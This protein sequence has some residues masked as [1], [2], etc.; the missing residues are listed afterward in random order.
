[1][2][3]NGDEKHGTCFPVAKQQHEAEGRAAEFRRAICL[4][5]ARVATGLELRHNSGLGRAVAVISA[6]LQVLQG[7]V[8]GRVPL[9]D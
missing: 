5:W 7:D 6:F 1:M 8:E 2:D 9:F 3:N 4:S